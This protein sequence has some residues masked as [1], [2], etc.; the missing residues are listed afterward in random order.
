M[1]NLTSMSS[2]CYC[3]ACLVFKASRSVFASC[4]ITYEKKKTLW[5]RLTYL[6]CVIEAFWIA[7]SGNQVFISN[8]KRG[9]SHKTVNRQTESIGISSPELKISFIFALWGKNVVHMNFTDMVKKKHPKKAFDKANNSNAQ[10]GELTRGCSHWLHIW[11]E[12]WGWWSCHGDIPSSH[13]YHCREN[14]F[15]IFLLPDGLI[16]GLK[17]YKAISYSLLFLLLLKCS[18]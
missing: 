10:Q 9:G 18:H 7:V 1:L 5:I 12:G 4:L 6:V 16:Q 15:H 11:E 2:I 8:F 14:K 3:F 17:V 13:S